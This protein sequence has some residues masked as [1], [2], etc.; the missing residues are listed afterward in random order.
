MTSAKNS[1]LHA[2]AVFEAAKG[3]AAISASVGLLSLAHHDVRAWAYALIGHFHLDPEA[4]YPR[5]LLDEATWL[6]HADLRQLV[7]LACGYAAIRWIEGY[8]LWNDRTWAEWLAASSGAIYLPI[9]IS[10][11]LHNAT[12]INCTVLGFNFWIVAYMLGRLWRQKKAA[13]QGPFAE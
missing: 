9:E 1:L 7:I 10:H 11:M 6:E 3:L 5:M 8:G 4:H 12:V 13:I 2:I